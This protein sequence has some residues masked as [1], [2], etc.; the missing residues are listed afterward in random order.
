MPYRSGTVALVYIVIADYDQHGVWIYDSTAGSNTLIQTLVHEEMRGR[1]M[2]LYTTAFM[3]TATFGSLLAGSTAGFIGAPQTLMA[4]GLVCIIGAGVFTFKLP[5]LREQA[6][7]VYIE[8]GILPQ[9]SES[10][11]EATTLQEEVEQ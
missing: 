7:L 8:K 5:A 4:G 1:V 11:R 9:V 3:G 6:R 10:L 2:A